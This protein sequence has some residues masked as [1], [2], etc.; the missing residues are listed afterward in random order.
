MTIVR[1]GDCGGRV[2]GSRQV[3]VKE[4]GVDLETQGERCCRTLR[5]SR[6][7]NARCSVLFLFLSIFVL[8]GQVVWSS[9]TTFIATGATWKYLDDGSDQGTGWTLGAFDDSS[10]A[11]GNAQLGY[12]D[13]DEA[14]LLGYGPDPD[15]KY[16]TTYFRHEFEVPNASSYHKLILRILRDDGAVVHLNGA[17]MFRTNISGDPIEYDTWASNAV[18]ESSEDKFYEAAH[19]TSDLLEGTNVLAVEIHQA[20]R[21]SSDIS[22]D[23]EL[24]G[25]TDPMVKGPYLIYPGH[26][27]RMT[28]LW[29][30]IGTASCTLE[31]GLNTS[32]GLG[33]VVSTEYGTDHQHKWTIVALAPGT[34]YFYRISV[35]DNAYTGSFRTAPRRDARVVEL[36]AYGDT[37]SN[38]DDHDAVC[39]EMISTYTV[40]PN[41]QSLLLHVGD[42][43]N[44]GDSEGSWTGEFFNRAWPNAMR[45]QA[46]IPIN[47]CM[48]NHE[49]SGGLFRKY[50]PYPYNADRYWSFD[51]GPVH[52]AIVDQYSD[53]GEGSDQL[54]WLE[55][56][57]AASGKKWKFLVFH[58]PGWSAGGHENNLDVQTRIQPL[59]ETYGVN[60]VFVGHNHYYARAVVNGIVHVTTGGGGAPLYGPDAGY[61]HVVTAVPTLQFCRISIDDN[62]LDLESVAPGGSI[63]DS[64][65]L[66]R[67]DF[68][69][70]DGAVNMRDFAILVN[71]W[72][73]SECGT[74]GGADLSGDGRVDMD[75]LVDFAEVWP[76][77]LQ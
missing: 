55:N 39:A 68:E 69:P 35:A 25:S 23:L 18:G 24:I 48:G 72:L 4:T 29:Q 49:G 76:S 41:R 52:I 15:N 67:G 30:F 61:P 14:T 11:S 54:I 46:E 32:Y 9:E 51:Y 47:G 19:D 60:I 75:D 16:I 62:Q 74:C 21:T 38:P 64:F 13:G 8:S 20:N 34:R 44:S 27:R 50:W 37:R 28:V 40:D 45:L 3:R 2:V 7:V 73:T 5:E 1:G 77:E 66:L 10:W 65:S 12:G 22:F 58:E 36:L 71:N 59:C 53:Y 6:C 26:A 43:V 70:G 63:I 31:W 17:E 56:D 33:S 42:W 57:L